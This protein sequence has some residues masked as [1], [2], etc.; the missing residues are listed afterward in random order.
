LERSLSVARSRNV[1]FDA[2]LALRALA[3]VDLRRRGEL[4]AESQELLDGLGGKILPTALGPLTQG[5]LREPVV[6]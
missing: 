3:D 5:A 2:A 4:L 1:A 6:S